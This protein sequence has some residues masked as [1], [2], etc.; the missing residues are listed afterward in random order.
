M[1]VD[2]FDAK[3]NASDMDSRYGSYQRIQNGHFDSLSDMVRYIET[4]PVKAVERKTDWCRTTTPQALVLAK[5]GWSAG[6]EVIAAKASQ[7]VNRLVN[8]TSIGQLHEIGYDTSGAAYDPGA[9][10]QGT[11]ECWGTIVPEVSKRA[12]H[13]IYNA[14]ASAG[15]PESVI[16]NRGIAVAA[17]VWML[18]V[19]GY[20]VTVDWLDWAEHFT[21]GT[22]KIYVRL[23][24]AVSGSQL[25]LDRLAFGLG[26]P[27]MFRRFGQVVVDG[28]IGE[29]SW[30]G[31]H[32]PGQA[33]KHPDC[34]L[35]IGGA[36]LS[37]AQRWTDGG[38][39]WVLAEFER[40]TK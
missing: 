27:A 2:P 34:D 14:S 24:D 35:F 11:P 29:G 10:C 36:H 32:H 17:L 38:E 13:I 4:L 12:I 1:R 40:Q 6:A 28:H 20:P 26:H 33:D 19:D 25:D 31:M 21:T 18:N 8:R 3:Y 37:D 39:A 9:L 22:S 5:D 15:V 30:W 16:Q 23:V 7:M